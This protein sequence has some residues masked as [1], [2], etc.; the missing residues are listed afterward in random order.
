MTAAGTFH[1]VPGISPQQFNPQY[2]GPVRAS[3][4]P[5]V[6]QNLWSAQDF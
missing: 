5:C 2:S 1:G 4:E 6:Q 3:E